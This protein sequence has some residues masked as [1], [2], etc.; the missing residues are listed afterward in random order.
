MRS[1]TIETISVLIVLQ[2]LPNRK[3]KANGR[4]QRKNPRNLN[5]NGRRTGGSISNDSALLL[6]PEYKGQPIVA[7]KISATPLILTPTLGVLAVNQSLSSALIPSFATRFQAYTEFRIVKVEA[8]IANFSSTAI[9][10]ANHWFSEDD[11]AAPTASKAINA[12]AD[13]FNWSDVTKEHIL[14][15]VPHDPAQQ[16]WTLVS[17]GA[18]VIGYFKLYTDIANFGA[19]SASVNLGIVDFELTVQLRGF[20]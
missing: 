10:L 3:T 16:T 13:R 2:M 15:F 17:S 12:K 19:A 5:G 14:S 9:G 7:H 18:P 11:T 20:I 8:K 1:L 6:R 4:A